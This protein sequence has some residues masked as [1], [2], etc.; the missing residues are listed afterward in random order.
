MP[1][2]KPAPEPAPSAEALRVLVVDDDRLHAETVAEVLE[3]VGYQCTVAT[4]GKGGAAAIDRD[5]F[6]V[7]LTDLRMNDFDGLAI[8]RKV[9]ADQPEAEVVVITGFGDVK[10]AVE[11]IKL[12][13]VHYLVKPVD[14]AELRAIVSR[15]AVCPLR[16]RANRELRRQLD[17]KFGFE[18]VVGNSQTMHDVLARLKAYAPTRAT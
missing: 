15:A 5:E 17:E 4:S 6:D 7:V 1:R 11:A 12:G 18:G 2:A 9:K 14:M 13:A 16:C 10:T 3:K 8:L